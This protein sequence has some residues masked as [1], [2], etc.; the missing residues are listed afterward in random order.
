MPP[1]RDRLLGMPVLRPRLL[2]VP[3]SRGELLRISVLHRCA[4]FASQNVL[5]LLT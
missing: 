3:D 2:G 4:S 5:A 1:L